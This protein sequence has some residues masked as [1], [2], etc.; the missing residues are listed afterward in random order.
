METCATLAFP[1]VCKMA[2]Q[3]LQQE[4]NG[5]SNNFPASYVFEQHGHGE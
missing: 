3:H 1:I 4:K 2:T 5:D